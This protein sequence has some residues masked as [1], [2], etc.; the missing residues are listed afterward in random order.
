MQFQ[1]GFQH[2]TLE[3]HICRLDVSLS[4]RLLGND[5]DSAE[6]GSLEVV[7]G[8]GM[9]DMGDGG[10][11]VCGGYIFCNGFVN[12]GCFLNLLGKASKQEARVIAKWR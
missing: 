11:H 10:G 9:K 3:P 8:T 4:A 12:H 1:P 7:G 2:E 5:R 6:V